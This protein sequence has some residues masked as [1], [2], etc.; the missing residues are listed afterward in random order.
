MRTICSVALALS[1]AMPACAADV[2]DAVPV[3]IHVA[4]DGADPGPVRL[5]HV[6]FSGEAPPAHLDL[7]AAAGAA[8]L[9]TARPPRAFVYSEG[10]QTRDKIHH[11]ASY[12]MLPLF[13]A[14]AYLG[15]HMFNNPANITPAMQT[16]HRAMGWGVAGLFGVNSLTGVWNLAEARKDPNGLAR[17]MIHAT[18]MLVADAGFTATAFTRPNS[19]TPD[20]LAIYTDKKN[21]HMALAYASVSV[22]T[23]GYL[24]MLFR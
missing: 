12:T 19:T 5:P 6:D 18:L 3:S 16:A 8:V 10:Y 23:V 15:Q 7:R 20:G 11:L 13:A 17:R 2:R 14:E 1:C 9:Q 22:A 24:L 21:Q 4:F